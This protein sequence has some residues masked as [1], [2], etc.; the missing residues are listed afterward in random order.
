VLFPS[1]SSRFTSSYSRQNQLRKLRRPT[2]AALIHRF[3]AAD[4][5][6]AVAR[7]TT[8]M[9]SVLFNIVFALAAIAR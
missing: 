7:V 8:P 9:A 2:A 3:V 4:G 5:G 1:A 6:D